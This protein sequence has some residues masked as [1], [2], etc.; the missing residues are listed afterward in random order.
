MSSVHQPACVFPRG[1]AGFTYL[2]LLFFV[3][4]MGFALASVALVWHTE[5]KR[6]KESELLFVGDEFRRAIQSYR[7]S[8]PGAPQLPASLDELVRDQR[9]PGV[10]RHLRRVY[11]DPLTGKTEWGLVKQPDD[12]I[13]GVYSLSE[14]PPKKTYGFPTEY[15]QFAKAVSYQ[16]WKFIDAPDAPSGKDAKAAGTPTGLPVPPDGVPG[17]VPLPGGENLCRMR[18]LVPPTTCCRVRPL[19]PPTICYRVPLPVPPL[20]GCRVH[21]LRPAAKALHRDTPL[22]SLLSRSA[23]RLRVLAH[24]A[25]DARG[26]VTGAWVLRSVPPPTL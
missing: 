10:K 15:A 8:S 25:P 13:I 17:A 7:T 26:C 6:E 19:V 18:F 1:V 2:G 14:E 4:I 3:A 16:D 24:A 22:Q 12:R 23:W 9:F 5:S 20:I 11:R 21:R